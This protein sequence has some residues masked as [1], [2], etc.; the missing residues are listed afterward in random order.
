M[1]CDRKEQLLLS[2]GEVV[3]D[4]ALAGSRTDEDVV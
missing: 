1:L 3:E 4:L 2:S